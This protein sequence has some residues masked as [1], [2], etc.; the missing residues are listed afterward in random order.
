ML[1][2]TL[3]IIKELLMEKP[4]LQERWEYISS[5]VEF[6]KKSILFFYIKGRNFGQSIKLVCLILSTFSEAAFWNED[7][8]KAVDKLDSKYNVVENIIE[9][10]K[11][12]ESIPQIKVSHKECFQFFY[13]LI[14]SLGSYLKVPLKTNHIE[15]L[16]YK[17]NSEAL[18]N[19]LRK[20]RLD[21]KF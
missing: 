1:L 9:G 5:C 2:F 20:S 13:E 17:S 18:L 8:K 12:I 16:W 3:N 14:D 19:Y 7:R 6:I 21:Q 11:N 10:F 4:F 15:F